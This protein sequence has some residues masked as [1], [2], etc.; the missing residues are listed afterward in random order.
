MKILFFF[1]LPKFVNITLIRKK[2]DKTFEE[3][4]QFKKIDK[5]VKAKKDT[6]ADIQMGLPRNNG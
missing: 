1:F 5:D 4:E 2:L 6:L 3:T